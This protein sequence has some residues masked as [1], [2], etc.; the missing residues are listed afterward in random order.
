MGAKAGAAIRA[1]QREVVARVERL[2]SQAE[3]RSPIGSA[4]RTAIKATA[5]DG[6][7]ALRARDRARDLLSAAEADAGAALLRIV[8]EGLTLAESFEAVGLSTSVG[9]RLYARAQVAG[10]RAAHQSSTASG[11]RG[12]SFRYGP[13]LARRRIPP[14][15][16]ATS[17]PTP[18]RTSRDRQHGH[19]CPRSVA[20]RAGVSPGQAETGVTVQVRPTRPAPL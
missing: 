10:T 1:R 8:A 20:S 9:R 18:S 15:V 7:R 6:R 2:V 13:R 3:E 19:G 17:P 4:R 11:F 5:R 14:P 16:L 12:A